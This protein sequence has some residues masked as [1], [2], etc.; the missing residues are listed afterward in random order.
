MRFMDFVLVL[1]K[2]FLFLSMLLSFETKV[3]ASNSKSEKP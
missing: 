2:M 3:P 1:D